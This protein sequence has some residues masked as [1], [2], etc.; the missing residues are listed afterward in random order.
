MSRGS[1]N[2]LGGATGRAEILEAACAD[3]FGNKPKLWST[4]AQSFRSGSKSM[5]RS[6]W[7]PTALRTRLPQ[8]GSGSATQSSSTS[9]TATTYDCITADGAFIG[10]IIQPGVRDFGRDSPLRR[11]S[12][13]A[14]TELIPPK[15]VIGTPEPTSAFDRGCFMARRIRLTALVLRIKQEWSVE[16]PIVIATGGLADTLKSYCESF[17]EVDPYLTL[18]GVKMGYDLLA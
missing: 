12:K 1:S 11:T 14:A 13:L 15:H 7:A 5:S 18:K 10:G 8:A 9:G 17:D 6:R 2:L 4:R 3:C 16:S